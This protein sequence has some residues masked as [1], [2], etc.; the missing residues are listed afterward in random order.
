M[1]ASPTK[2]TRNVSRSSRPRSTT[3]GP[4][5]QPDDPLGS[6]TVN[7]AASPR[8]ATAGDG[9]FTGASFSRLD[10]LRPD[11]LP[12]TV[13][14]DLSY[15]LR[16]D[17]YH[18]LSQVEIPHALRSEFLAPTSDESLSTSL[19][20]LERL[21]AEGHFLL[22]AYLCGTILTSSLISATDIKR[23]FAL[24]YTRLAC[25]QLS[26]NTIIAAQESKALEDLSSAFY[27]VE[28]ISGTSDKHSNYPRHIVPWPLRVLAI[29]LQSIGFGDSRRGIGGLYE[30][31][32]EARRE[33]LRPD[34]DPEERKLWRERLSDLGMRNVNALIEM[35]DL[36][37]ARRSLASLRMAESESEINK[38]RKVLLMLIIGDLDAARQVCGEESDA[39][40]T[41]FRPLLSMAEGRYDDAVA[42]WRALLGNEEHR[43]DESMISQNLAVCLLYTGRLNEAREVLESL[44]HTNHSFSSLVF[45]LSTVY[46]L[47]SDKSAKLKTDLVETV[48]RQP[49]TG[50]TNLDRPNG[51]FKL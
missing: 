37:A 51:D 24:F 43:P 8:P 13:E 5:D 28:P 47:C 4:L 16:Y 36:D 46:E 21:L 1:D 30:I 50:T 19:A 2:H 44:V 3:K 40:N 26:G 12:P 31:G 9:G 29:R 48:A 32:L 25:L 35:G 41:V 14:K 15:L 34:M 33:I 23:I 27:Y 49:V 39:G 7:T 11:E 18:S 6:E 38:L 45:N 17:V 42:E 20:T 10:P 22:A